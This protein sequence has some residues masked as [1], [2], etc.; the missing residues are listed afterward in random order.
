M[1]RIPLIGDSQ[2]LAKHD[3][4]YFRG[5]T[6]TSLLC[7]MFKNHL[8]KLLMF[9][10]PV[11]K[12]VAG[13]IL[14]TV[15]CTGSFAQTSTAE[16]SAA[17]TS[18]TTSVS[19]SNTS[20][21]VAGTGTTGLDAGDKTKDMAGPAPAV[22]PPKFSAMRLRMSL[23]EADKDSDATGKQKKLWAQ[24]GLDRDNALKEAMSVKITGSSIAGSE[25]VTLTHAQRTIIKVCNAGFDYI[26]QRM[27]ANA[28]S[29]FWVGGAAAVLGIGGAAATVIRASKIMTL[30]SAGISAYKSDFLPSADADHQTNS[31]KLIA[32]DIRQELAASATDFSRWMFA[33]TPDKAAQRTQ[34]QHLQASLIAAN[35]ACSFF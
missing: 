19:G 17:G 9:I 24:L 23:S 30:S 27:N 31:L 3:S 11:F 22:V 35:H 15:L 12:T 21:G 5:L 34:L 26:E 20:T 8:K 33:S 10:H 2:L 28:K 16:K 13:S 6:N 1:N 4:C 32:D 18:A 14:L 29:S 25:L 7:S